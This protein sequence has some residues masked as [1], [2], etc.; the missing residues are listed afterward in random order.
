MNFPNATVPP[1]W[2]GIQLQRRRVKGYCPELLTA[3]LRELS[4]YSS[5]LSLFLA[6]RNDDSRLVVNTAPKVA[7]AADAGGGNIRPGRGY[8]DLTVFREDYQ[9]TTLGQTS[10]LEFWFCNR[11]DVL[12][13]LGVTDETVPT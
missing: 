1:T 6:A 3:A 2:V 4:L 12:Q 10:L 13:G 9:Q 7:W 11:L 5:V 8:C